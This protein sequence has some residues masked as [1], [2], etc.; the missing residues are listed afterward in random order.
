M[1][2]QLLNFVF[3]I[4]LVLSNISAHAE[5]KVIRNVMPNGDSYTTMQFEPNKFL[6]QSLVGGIRRCPSKQPCVEAAHNLVVSSCQKLG[7]QLTG[8]IA[9][10]RHF[11]Y[12]N[13][14]YYFSVTGLA[15][16]V[17]SP[18]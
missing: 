14:I 10:D 18:H 2:T 13:P 15:V 5:D 12:Q 16:C 8:D 3:G 17:V 11:E 1:P 7:G 9:M 6:I 4:T